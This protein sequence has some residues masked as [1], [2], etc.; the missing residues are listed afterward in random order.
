[1][2]L[3]QPWLGR[4]DVDQHVCWAPTRIYFFYMSSSACRLV[5]QVI[6]RPCIRQ[7]PM[8]SSLQKLLLTERRQLEVQAARSQQALLTAEAHIQHMQKQLEQLE[9]PSCSTDAVEQGS[10]DAA[11]RD[12]EQGTSTNRPPSARRAATATLSCTQQL[13]L[14]TALKDQNS[15][16]KQNLQQLQQQC[17]MLAQPGTVVSQVSSL[18]SELQSCLA[19]LHE[20]SQLAQGIVARAEDAE[21]HAQEASAESEAVKRLLHQVRTAAVIAGSGGSN[22]T[23]EHMCAV[24]KQLPADAINVVGSWAVVC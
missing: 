8:C 6:S 10:A 21:S 9:P 11:V 18:P 17:A 3:R 16:L 14:I 22:A 24:E 23:G 1:M 12:A 4:H 7:K 2:L 20:Q 19:Q 5:Q 15:M 13:C